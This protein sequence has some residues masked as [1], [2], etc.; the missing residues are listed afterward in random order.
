MGE[1]QGVPGETAAQ[2]YRPVPHLSWWL[3]HSPRKRPLRR[4]SEGRPLQGRGDIGLHLLL[5]LHRVYRPSS[6]R[7]RGGQCARLRAGR[8]QLAIV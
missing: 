1:E 5:A 6:A 4:N 7:G 3:R 2:Q 8:G